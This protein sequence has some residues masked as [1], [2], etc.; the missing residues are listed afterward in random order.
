LKE[1]EFVD[2][3]R[4]CEEEGDLTRGKTF[5]GV[6]RVEG[7]DITGKMECRLD[8]PIEGTGGARAGGVACVSVVGIG[9][10]REDVRLVEGVV[11]RGK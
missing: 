8:P 2:W 6:G 7:F 11:T 5:E 10:S 1:V 3:E 4:D 9:G